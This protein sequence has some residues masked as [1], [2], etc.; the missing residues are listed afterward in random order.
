MMVRIVLAGLCLALSG[1]GNDPNRTDLARLP[2]ITPKNSPAPTVTAQQMATA[3]LAQLSE[4]V[5]LAV[6]EEPSRTALLVP[7]GDNRAVLTWTTVDRQTI[8]LS[9]GRIVA[10]RGLGADLMSSDATA[11]R[12]GST[13]V[14]SMTTLNSANETIR[15][16]VACRIDSGSREILTLASG[17]TISTLR[18]RENCRGG[19]DAWENDFWIAGDGLVRQSRQHLGTEI[20]SLTLQV[21]RP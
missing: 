21:L 15:L 18:L 9:G 1:C 8:S 5:I 13:S 20:G 7:L 14:H 12:P 17:E 11:P 6:L 2:G 4:P 3:A 16:R 19:T 10:T